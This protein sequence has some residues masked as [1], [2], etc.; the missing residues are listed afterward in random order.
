MRSSSSLIGGV[1]VVVVIV[2]A[3][4]FFLMPSGDGHEGA[5]QTSPHAI[6]QTP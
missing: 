2:A 4:V 5:G 3:L 1:V 6:E